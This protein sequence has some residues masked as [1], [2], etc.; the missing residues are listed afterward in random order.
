MHSPLFSACIPSDSL[1]YTRGGSRGESAGKTEAEQHTGHQAKP[2]G[3]S[4]GGEGTETEPALIQEVAL[5]YCTNSTGRSKNPIY[6][7][8]RT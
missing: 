1:I 3:E 8:G 7:H 2:T 6:Q 4:L 5:I